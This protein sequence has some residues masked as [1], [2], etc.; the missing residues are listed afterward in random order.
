MNNP[1]QVSRYR[2][3][4]AP[5]ERPRLGLRSRPHPKPHPPP[6]LQ[7]PRPKPHT[8][9]P[10]PKPT[11]QAH[12][13][14]RLKTASPPPRLAPHH[15]CQRISSAISQASLPPPSWHS[16]PSISPAN[17]SVP[18]PGTASPPLPPP[19]SSPF[20]II[21]ND[22]LPLLLPPTN[23]TKQTKNTPKKKVSASFCINPNCK[24]AAGFYCG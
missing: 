19:P 6:T 18:A 22:P 13:S 15:E 16:Y 24:L 9:S 3:A 12:V 21:T 23:E 5:R 7:A 20:K 4:F 2:R 17:T 10:R 1:L 8:P 14:S 11:P